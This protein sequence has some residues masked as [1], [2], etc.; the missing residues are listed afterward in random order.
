MT[1]IP[2]S[3]ILKILQT[4]NECQYNITFSFKIKNNQANS[5]NSKIDLL[6]SDLIPLPS[7][8]E[9]YDGILFNIVW[10]QEIQ[11][12]DN[13]YCL[14]KQYISNEDIICYVTVFGK[15]HKI[16]SGYNMKTLKSNNF[17]YLP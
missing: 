4:S 1:K 2:S 16:N 9:V 17:S 14:D 13:Y 5:I 11:N 10:I 8:I 7:T 12:N 3:H 6:V 15:L